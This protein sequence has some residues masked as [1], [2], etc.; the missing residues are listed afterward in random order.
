MN[1]YNLNKEKAIDIWNSVSLNYQKAREE[2]QQFW[3]KK[4][5]LM[6]ILFCL[7]LLPGILYYFFSWNSYE[8]KTKREILANRFLIDSFQYIKSHS[9]NDSLKNVDVKYIYEPP[10][11]ISLP[12]TFSSNFLETLTNGF[13]GLFTNV[14]FNQIGKSFDR[15]T[16]YQKQLINNLINTNLFGYLT[17][18]RL[19]TLRLAAGT[20]VSRKLHIDSN[21]SLQIKINNQSYYIFNLKTWVVEVRKKVV[22]INKKNQ[23]IYTTTKINTFNGATVFSDSFFNYPA[24][25]YIKNKDIKNKYD[26]T[27]G[28]YL[29][30]KKLQYSLAFDEF[31]KQI[32]ILTNKE[33][34]VALRRLFQP[35]TLNLLYD[36]LKLSPEFIINSLNGRGIGMLFRSWHKNEHTK[37]FSI[38]K[39]H[40]FMTNEEYAQQEI[41]K[42]VSF[43]LSMTNFISI[44]EQQ[45]FN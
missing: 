22:N 14:I 44:F 2:Y 29:N 11:S 16:T 23:V 36:S 13:G 18:I 8:N 43:L 26:E 9:T 12:L 7:F 1:N 41:N 35:R 20:L 30:I 15:Q 24:N 38:D 27:V 21:C 19:S 34:G 28:G 10:S 42:N 39:A 40:K 37:T 3:G 6:I 32:E 33:D 45:M 25:I 5:K 31:D 17:A 4:F